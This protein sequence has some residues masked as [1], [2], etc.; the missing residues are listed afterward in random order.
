M[1]LVIY[2]SDSVV[3]AVISEVY[4]GLLSTQSHCLTFKCNYYL[5][6]ENSPLI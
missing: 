5:H 6:M 2:C 4:K 3:S 1:I